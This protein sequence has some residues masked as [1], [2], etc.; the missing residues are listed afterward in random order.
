M[1]P[2]RVLIG[3][4]ILCLTAGAASHPRIYRNQEFGIT[5]PVPPDA[6][7]CVPPRDARGID[8]GPQMLLGTRDATLCRKWSGK[9]YM[10]VF[11]FYNASDD[12][13]LLHD[14]LESSCQDEVKKACSDAPAGL[15]IP[16]M[17]TDAGRLDHPEGSVRIIVV[18]QAGKPD[19][20]FDASVP[21]INYTLT[22]NTDQS[23]LDEDLT[24]FRA[25]LNTV[26]IAPPNP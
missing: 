13:R 10:E 5:L 24:P 21:S 7:L 23:H 20:D 15:H 11:A 1:A 14:L 12:T 4:V 26:K 6:L 16:R 9:R 22:L 18:T 25:M 19:P 3:L 8:H 2:S 17:K